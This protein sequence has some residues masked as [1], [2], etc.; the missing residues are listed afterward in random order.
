[1]TEGF[2]LFVTRLTFFFD[3]FLPYSVRNLLKVPGG[4]RGG[5]GDNIKVTANYDMETLNFPQ[6][7]D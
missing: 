5:V 6:K 2:A 7:L 1:M 4:G 3:T